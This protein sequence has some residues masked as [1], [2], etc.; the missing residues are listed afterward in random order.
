VIVYR[1]V[2]VVVR[3]VI[4]AVWGA[5]GEGAALP[6]GPLIVV[7]NHDS[8]LDPFVLGAALER[9]LRFVAKEELWANRLV[10]AVLAALGGIPVRRGRGDLDAVDR[11]AVALRA[12]GVVAIFPQGTVL[13][14]D[15]R[16]WHRG[17]ARLALGTGVPIVPVRIVGA[18][19]ALRPGTRRLRRARVRVLV[20]EPI[21]VEPARATIAVARDLTARVRASIESLGD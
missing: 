21:P 14:S 17:A 12:G 15:G 5:R 2:R 18:E 13:G 3:P 16:V 11:A 7:S 6:A 20:G 9:P 10:G 1:S 19:R 8:L 4:R